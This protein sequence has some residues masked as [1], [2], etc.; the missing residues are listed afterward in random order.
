MTVKIGPMRAAFAG[1][2]NVELDDVSRRGRIRGAGSDS[3]SGSRT[4]TDATYRV[5]PNE[6]G[7]GSLV[8]LTVEYNLQG[9]LAQFS[10][11][12]LVQDI[13]RRLIADFSANL[14]SRL[15][16]GKPQDST[17]QFA[18]LDAGGMLIGVFKQWFKRL[19]LSFKLG[20]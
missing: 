18:P 2:A 11:S 6:S 19:L 1:S 17:D 10:R 20:A 14:N 13:G 15:Q 16:S 12:G 7:A 5:E 9:P 3:G 4:K 8:S